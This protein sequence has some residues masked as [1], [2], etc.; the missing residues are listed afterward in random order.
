MNNPLISIIVPVYNA[1]KT[2]NRCVDSIVVQ[3]FT[4]WELLLINDG[5]KDHSGEISD[6]YALKDSRIR[7]FHKENG[8]VSSARNVGLDNA[9]GEW[10]T[11]CDADDYV[12]SSWLDNFICCIND[13][14]DL[15]C[16]SFFSSRSLIDSSSH[17]SINGFEYCGDKKVGL[18]KLYE[19]KILG[20][21]WIKL[22]RKEI[23]ERYILRFNEMFNFWEDQIFCIEYIRCIDTISYTN[24]IG[25]YYSVPNWNS[26]YYIKENL[27]LVYQSIYENFSKIFG[28]EVNKL[29]R[30][31]IDG[32]IAQVLISYKNGDRQC[33]DHLKTMLKVLGRDLLKSHLFFWTK[34]V[35]YFDKTSVF[36]HYV[37]KMHVKMKKNI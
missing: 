31:S 10:I 13:K 8:G 33:R 19:N 27:I 14:S 25:Y 23:I 24:K 36:S 7:V 1:E 16:Q 28:E 15:I 34:W 20:Y 32:Y 3:T 26:K 22:F 6:K 11:F 4:N 5:S 35:I 17:E 37:L 9:R 30:D 2:L 29:V 18:I 21:L 12:Y